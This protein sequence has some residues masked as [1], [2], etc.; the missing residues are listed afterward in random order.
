MAAILLKQKTGLQFI[1]VPY[2]ATAETIV[3]ILGN[4]IDA[5]MED[6]STAIGRQ[7]LKPLVIMAK[8][9]AVELPNLPT[10]GEVGYENI[11]HDYTLGMIA[12]PGVPQDRVK[13]LEAA[14]DKAAK[15][16]AYVARLKEAKI[17]QVLLNAADYLKF[18]TEQY[19]R[20]KAIAPEIKADMTG[21]SK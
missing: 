11:E 16:P 1:L 14:F 4:K 12:P 2:D 6:I 7:D 13:I 15:D 19:N 17:H 20:V 18:E 8:Q 10:L 21:I 5:M 3:A 9:R